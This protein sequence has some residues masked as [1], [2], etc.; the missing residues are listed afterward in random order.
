MQKDQKKAIFL[1]GGGYKMFV[2]QIERITGTLNCITQT[3]RLDY[4]SGDKKF[5]E[6]ISYKNTKSGIQQ[7]LCADSSSRDSY[8]LDSAQKSEINKKEMIFADNLAFIKTDLRF[9]D[10]KKFKK[11]F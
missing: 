11:L 10:T 8:Y 9:D 1:I 7:L 5:I 6:S 2:N 4:F 3:A